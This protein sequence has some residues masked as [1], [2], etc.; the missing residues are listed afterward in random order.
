MTVDKDPPYWFI[1]LPIHE[2]HYYT[3]GQTRRSS[4]LYK[5]RLI[6]FRER[7]PLGL[8]K[9]G[10]DRCSTRTADSDDRPA[11]AFQ[12]KLTEEALSRGARNAAVS[13]D[14]HGSSW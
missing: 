3:V 12:G 9:A 8:K 13:V 14:I 11:S 7:P 2:H 4:L 1:R 6:R 10:V 5:S